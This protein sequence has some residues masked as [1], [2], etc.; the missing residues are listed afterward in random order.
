MAAVVP[1]PVLSSLPAILNCKDGSPDIDFLNGLCKSEVVKSFGELTLADK[2]TML[3]VGKKTEES[4]NGLRGMV[5]LTTGQVII[6]TPDEAEKVRTA[7][8]KMF[9]ILVISGGEPYKTH[10]LGLSPFSV[11]GKRLY[12]VQLYA[13]LASLN[14]RQ[15]R[16]VSVGAKIPLGV[17]K[18]TILPSITGSE[19][20]IDVAKT[21]VHK[22]PVGAPPLIVLFRFDGK[23]FQTMPT[24]WKL[25][26][27]Y[28]WVSLP[29][30]DQKLGSFYARCG[31]AYCGLAHL[32]KA[33]GAANALAI[34]ED[35]VFKQSKRF[36]KAQLAVMET[37]LRET[38]MCDLAASES[39]HEI[40]FWRK[41]PTGP[42]SRLISLKDE[43]TALLSAFPE[44]LQKLNEMYNNKLLVRLVSVVDYRLQLRQLITMA[45][46]RKYRLVSGTDAQLVPSQVRQ[47]VKDICGGAGYTVGLK[48]G[49]PGLPFMNKNLTWDLGWVFDR[50]ELKKDSFVWDAQPPRVAAPA[51]PAP[52]PDDESSE[53]DEAEEE[54]EAPAPEPAAPEEVDDFPPEFHE[55][56]WPEGW[57]PLEVVPEPKG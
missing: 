49:F 56:G 8:A 9:N 42:E 50:D 51:P 18:D 11:D 5:Q 22:A 45:N 44:S 16:L 10:K 25:G 37:I 2:S 33:A 36:V 13:V 20:V 31:T 7:L 41:P 28:G 40:R 54:A 46:D 29:A 52:Q 4:V 32:A 55:G 47:R 30:S 53:E 38:V 3:N 39:R 34:P 57:E 12:G 6:V 23:V 21:I 1:N 27:G 43:L 15:I 48:G 14:I 24:L 35:G 26:G 19:V 17:F